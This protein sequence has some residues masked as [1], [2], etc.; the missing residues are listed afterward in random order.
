M[1][2]ADAPGK[3]PHVVM[4]VANDIVTD[5]RVK[6]EALAVAAMGLRVTLLGLASDR[7]AR[8][9][10]LGSVDIVRLDV[11]FPRRTKRDLT[12]ARR[13]EYRPRLVGPTQHPWNNPDATG[14]L[15]A[16]RKLVSALIVG[17]RKG[18]RRIDRK[19]TDA[20]ARHDT[21]LAA[22]TRRAR[23][24]TVLPEVKDYEEAFAPAVDALQPDII[25]AH[26]MHLLRVASR[27][28]DRARQRG[29]TVRWIYD[30][31]EYVPGLSL[32]GARTPRLVA[33]WASLEADYIGTADRVITVSPAIADALRSRYHLNHQP[34]VVLNTPVIEPSHD[35]ATP[36][37]RAV[38]G[39][40]EG[41]PLL[42]YAGGVTTARGVH[43]VVD[44]LPLLPEAHLV[45]VC[46]PRT[47]ASYPRR[48]QRQAV[49]LQVADRLHLLEPVPVGQIVGFLRTADVGLIP[50]LQFPSHQMALPNKV[51]EYLHAGLPVVTTELDT[52]G[53]F[54]R[55]HG[56]GEAF[57][58][59]DPE[60]LAEAA[61]KVLADHDRYAANARDPKL[62]ERFSWVRQETA[63]A[64]VYGELLGADLVD[65]AHVGDDRVIDLTERPLEG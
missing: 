52:L 36:S 1:T 4:M 34:T 5:T 38:A 12:R 13:R 11:P 32:Y 22:S 55:E 40:P 42:V 30:A 21:R 60:A 29:R 24:Q 17:R 53:P 37:I 31:H 46:V 3:T 44:A 27:A 23:W 63:L 54:V 61:R 7:T 33:A 19:L 41:A 26:D 62:L 8:R 45:V 18:E 20:W 49:R 14:L 25:H 57:T 59:E 39:V 56:I 6:R 10:R 2:E 16:R 47:D 64:E 15:L 50:V 28:A 48:L 9:S 43:V 58:A 65:R 35:D 51:F